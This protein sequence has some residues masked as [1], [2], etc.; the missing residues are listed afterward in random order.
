[1]PPH[2]GQRKWKIHSTASKPF[3]KISCRLSS[4]FKVLAGK[5][6]VKKEEIRILDDSPFFDTRL[7]ADGT[8]SYLGSA[9]RRNIASAGYNVPLQGKFISQTIIS[10]PT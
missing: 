4:A 5:Y 6:M 1:M 7:L 10:S 2:R 8:L 3:L 9:W